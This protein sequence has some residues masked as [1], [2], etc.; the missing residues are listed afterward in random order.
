MPLASEACFSLLEHLKCV[1]ERVRRLERVEA[2]DPIDQEAVKFIRKSL[3]PAWTEVADRVRRS[4]HADW[5]ALDEAI[6]RRAWRL[7]PSDFG[8]HNALTTADGRTRF[9]D[10]EYAG[11]DDP[12]RMV[13]DFFCQP[14]VP[15][16][17]DYLDR[18][19]ASVSA[20]SEE[21][22]ATLARIRLLFPVYRIKWC[23][24]LLNDFLLGGDRRRRFALSGD[25]Q[26]RK[27]RQLAKARLA[28]EAVLITRSQAPP[29]NDCAQG[30][31]L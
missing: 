5:V 27:A 18:F 1:A 3:I 25:A 2:G 11:W 4:A 29:G 14:A 12:A 28:L 21:P 8:F 9:F 7:S 19:A 15:V 22:D 17:L 13:C 26:E 20:D 23:C 30:S 24:I 16:P 10:F 31:A 6:S